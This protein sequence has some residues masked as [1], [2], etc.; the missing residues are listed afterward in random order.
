MNNYDYPMGADTKDAPWNQEDP[1][2][3]TIEVTVSITLS[4]TMKI[5]VDDYTAEGEIDEDSGDYNVYY[6]Y[7][8][9][10]LRKAVEEQVYL[11]NEAYRNLHDAVNATQNTRAKRCLEDLKGWEVDD[12]EVILEE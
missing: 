11:P 3:R 9:C 4:K 8:D 2:P 5:E 12:F 10:D 6:D 1:E 7:S